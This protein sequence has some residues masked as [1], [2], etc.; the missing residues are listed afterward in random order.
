[1]PHFRRFY[2]STEPPLVARLAKEV[3]QHLPN[4]IIADW[5]QAIRERCRFAS[6]TNAIEAIAAVNAD[7][8][9]GDWRPLRLQDAPFSVPG[10]VVFTYFPHAGERFWKNAVFLMIGRTAA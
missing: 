3:L 4:R 7:I 6:L 10:A 1:M 2:R 8:G 5:L 9:P